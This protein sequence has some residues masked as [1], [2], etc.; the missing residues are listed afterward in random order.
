MGVE[1]PTDIGGWNIQFK[2]NR[3]FGDEFASG[4]INKSVSS[5][6]NNASG[7]NVTSSGAGRFN[8]SINGVDT[9]G[10]DTGAYSYQVV[11]IDSGAR[12]VLSEGYINLLP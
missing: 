3:R 5:G 8:I 6:L 1:P 4:F 12:T 11:R 2:V 10:M 7:I 9:S